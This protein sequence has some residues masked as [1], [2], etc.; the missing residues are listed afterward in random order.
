MEDYQ[1][2]LAKLHKS[3][4]D[5]QF[6][7]VVI[8]EATGKTIKSKRRII[9]GEVSEV[10]DVTL[11]NDQHVII[12]INRGDQPTYYQEKWAIAQCKKIGIPVPE[13]LLIKSTKEENGFLSICV[14]EKIDGE[15]LERG[16]INF[17]EWDEKRRHKIIAQS[18]EVLA[19][20]HS[21][22]VNGYGSLDGEGN[23]KF[24]TFKSL[25]SHNLDKVEDMMKIAKDISVPDK[26]MEKAFF[27]LEKE[28][29]KFDL[30][31]VLTH[32]DYNVKHIMV[33]KEDTIVGIIDWGD[34]QGHS[35]ERDFASW[36][37][38]FDEYIPTKWLIEGY[39]D[40]KVFEGDFE[41]IVHWYK[42]DQGLE[43]M[44]WYYLQKYENGVKAAVEKLKKDILFFS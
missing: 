39:S 44:H 29:K 24:D 2:Y 9:A 1:S 6:I 30:P 38:W 26:L 7:S 21:I 25:M 10:Y 42:I 17:L 20:I 5:D 36:Y 40:K 28:N 15:P 34:V 43:I 37:Y 4:T 35:L 31:S 18:G 27:I 33:D 41:E 32:S 14:M 19:K 23:G 3:S 13:I 12:R 11:D 22:K 8:K 16:A